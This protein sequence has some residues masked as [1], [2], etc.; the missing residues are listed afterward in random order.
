MLIIKHLELEL[1]NYLFE[2]LIFCSFNKKNQTKLKQIKEIS[3]SFEMS[4]SQQDPKQLIPLEE[5]SKTSNLIN[6]GSLESC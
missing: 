3:L 5:E 1:N 4:Q 6:L 2:I